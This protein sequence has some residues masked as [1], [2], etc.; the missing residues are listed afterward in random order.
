MELMTK[1]AYNTGFA[2]M[3]VDAVK[4][5][6][7]TEQAEENTGVQRFEDVDKITFIP[8]ETVMYVRVTAE[9][10]GEMR[11]D[12]EFDMCAKPLTATFVLERLLWS[13]LPMTTAILLGTCIL[14][15][16]LFWLVGMPLLT[17]A[18]GPQLIDETKKGAAAAEVD[19]SV[20]D[21]N[22]ESK[23]TK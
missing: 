7:G 5:V 8:A 17:W 9:Y 3:I 10:D 1:E 11:H 19:H 6:V 16:L 14:V 13:M 22:K 18:L 15:V 12:M 23:K 2:K 20:V 4:S 21:E